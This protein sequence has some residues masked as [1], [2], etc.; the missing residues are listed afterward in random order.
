MF[1]VGYGYEKDEFGFNTNGRFQVKKR[2]VREDELLRVIIHLTPFIC[3]LFS[4]KTRT[5][6][7]VSKMLVSRVGSK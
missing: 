3:L 2:K 1:E 7:F 5:A 4:L 6:K